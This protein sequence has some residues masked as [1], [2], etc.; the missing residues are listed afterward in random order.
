MLEKVAFFNFP[1][2]Y[3]NR[4]LFFNILL[5]I[6]IGITSQDNF[7]INNKIGFGILAVLAYYV[8]K[9]IGRNIKH[10]LIITILRSIHFK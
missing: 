7:A 4:F 8:G 10:V 3:P 9:S 2:N 1:Q 5:T 6:S